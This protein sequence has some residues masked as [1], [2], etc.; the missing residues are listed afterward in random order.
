MNYEIEFEVRAEGNIQIISKNKE[1]NLST[2]T[3]QGLEF[4]RIFKNLKDGDRI[5]ALFKD[6]K[7]CP[8]CEHKL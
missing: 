8:L 4:E 3:G 2:I 7:I 1:V 6:I 5:T